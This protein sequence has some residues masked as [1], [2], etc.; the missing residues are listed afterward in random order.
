MDMNERDYLDKIEVRHY[1]GILLLS[2][3]TLLLELALTRVLSVTLYY[4]FG[5]LIISTALLGFGASG[6]V[7]AVW[8]GLRV[9]APL[10]RT[11]AWLAI[12]FGLVTLASFWAMQHIPFDPFMLLSDPWQILLMPMSYLLL[13]APFFCSGL[14]IALRLTRGSRRIN[15]LY[16]ADLVGAAA[17]CAAVALTMGQVGGSGSVALAAAVGMLSASVF[18]YRHAARIAACAA[19]LGGCIAGF[20]PFAEQA[21]PIRI[22]SEKKHP[23]KESASRPVYT[24]WNTF[25]RID[26]YELPARPDEGWPVPGLGVVIDGG[27]AGTGIGDL[28]DGVS[29][30]LGNPALY[31][32]PGI[33]FVGKER[34][35]VLVIGSGAGREVLEALAFG[36]SSI[37]AVEV[38]DIINDVVTRRF[39]ERT[40]GLFDRPEVRV[41]SDEGRSFV[42]RSGETYDAIIAIQTISNSTIAAGA[43]GLTESYMFT[44]EAFEDFL[45]HLAPDGILLVTRPRTQLA[46]FAATIREVL[47]Q[48]GIA[49]A[50]WHVVGFRS[51]LAPFGPRQPHDGLLFKKARFTAEELSAIRER[52]ETR[53][54]GLPKLG[55]PEILYSPLDSRPGEPIHDILTTSDLRQ[56]Y[57]EQELDLRPSTDDWPFFNLQ[58]QWS[59][60][61]PRSVLYA[62][63]LGGGHLAEHWIAVVAIITLL[64]QSTIIAVILILLPLVRFARQGLYVPACWKYLVYFAG[65]GL[66]FIMIEIVYLQRFTLFLGQP[67]YTFSVILA[68]LLLFTGAGAFATDRFGTAT[69]RLAAATL[70]AAIGA[71][72]VTMLALPWVFTVSLGL[73]IAWRVMIAV[74]AVAPTGFLL[75]MPFPIGLRMVHGSAPALVPWAWGVNGFFTVIGSALAML[76]GPALGFTATSIAAACCYG[77]A[78]LS[79]DTKIQRPES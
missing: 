15:R 18:S 16:A 50:A 32:A 59:S 66:G 65:L 21:I 19:V 51:P 2:L 11:L 5:F 38:N 68:T 28:R 72:V 79:L 54:A 53:S 56:F 52:L 7:L 27:S 40:G 3:G 60:V 44:K 10:D 46:R 69:P 70:G 55:P 37:A 34:P 73:P 25:S 23:L 20:A 39:R 26:V 1:V 49:D 6:V 78:L 9:R 62:F 42:R 14:A 58:V 8:P 74:A 45:D 47:E 22:T 33:A 24:A 76:L 35:R 71:M 77:A 13:S 64:G 43:M 48:R 41:F 4:H 29:A 57:R 63:G 36:A 67:V 31:R 30:V 61:G 75:G 17:G 12:V